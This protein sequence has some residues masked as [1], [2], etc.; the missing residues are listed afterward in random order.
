LR[1]TV[2]ELGDGIVNSELALIGKLQNAGD[3]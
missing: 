1:D 2:D 3:G